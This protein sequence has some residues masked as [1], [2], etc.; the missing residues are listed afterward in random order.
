MNA[1]WSQSSCS[2]FNSHSL[3]A[4][5]LACYDNRRSQ[6]ILLLRDVQFSIHVYRA[7]R[8][9]SIFINNPFGLACYCL[10]PFPLL[11]TARPQSYQLSHRLLIAILSVSA[12]WLLASTISSLTAS[13]SSDCCTG[14]SQLLVKMIDYIM[15]QSTVNWRRQNSSTLLLSCI[16]REL[17]VTGGKTCDPKIGESLLRDRKASGAYSSPPLSYINNHPTESLSLV[18]V[19]HDFQKCTSSCFLFGWE[20]KHKCIE[21]AFLW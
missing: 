5:T 3:V 2:F 10:S 9:L 8:M 17:L 4:I 6:S 7:S 19:T 16:I 14:C 21:Q 18:L 20:N 11:P 12:C 1:K 13:S 15:M